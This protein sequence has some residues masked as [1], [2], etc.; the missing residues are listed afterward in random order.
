MGSGGD[1]VIGRMIAVSPRDTNRFYIRLLLCYRRGPQSY[2]DLRTV[3]G[4]VHDSFKAAALS[5]GLLESDEENHRCLTE[6]TSFQ[7][8]GQMR[9]LFGVLLIYCDPASPSELW[10][11]HL[12]A[13]SEDYLRDEIEPTTK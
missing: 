7:M 3:D 9:H 10:S 2:E 4:V 12:S 11:T 5:M 6:A 8:P 13:L 1:K